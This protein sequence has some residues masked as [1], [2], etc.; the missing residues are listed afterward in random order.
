MSSSASVVETHP[1]SLKDKVAIV[2][3]AGSG[4]G[5]AMANLFAEHGC[6]VIVADVAA[7]RVK[8]VTD[9]IRI[10]SGST[11]AMVVDLSIK[12]EVD[13]M[14]DDI[15]NAFGNVDILCNNAGIMDGAL[16]AGETTDEVWERVMAINPDAPFRAS[17]KVI[18]SMIARG[19]GVILNIA[20]I[21]G[22]FG[23]RA[24]VAYTVS[25]HG[26]VGLTKSIAASYG[27]KG[28]RCN[29]TVL[30]AVNTA[31]GIGSLTPSPLGM[32]NLDKTLATLPRVGDPAEVARLALF[33]VSSDSSFLNGSCVIADAGWTAF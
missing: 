33:L 14:I 9:E 10:A 11:S 12:H 27:A 26:L 18:P 32:E 15:L 25:K 7:E 1:S 22:V 30:G 23:G 28:I 4:V 31:I 20:S 8:L 29:A 6:T 13:K 17:R 24:G 3:G 19:S 2:T 21:A 5:R 16:P